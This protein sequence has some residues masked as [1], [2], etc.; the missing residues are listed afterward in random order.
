VASLFRGTVLALLLLVGCSDASP[1][2]SSVFRTPPP[3]AGSVE[4]TPWELAEDPPE[5]FGPG[6]AAFDSP[7]DLLQALLQKAASPEGG[8]PDG[9]QLLAGI[10]DMERRSAVAWIQVIGV[11]D[12][13]V[14]GQELVLALARDASGWHVAGMRYRSHCRLGVDAES[15][16]C[17]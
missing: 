1:S 15:H 8:L 9:A 13:S 5:G 10:V 7:G 4:A 3:L 17:L 11:G 6:I 2:P 12:G 14:A 16:L